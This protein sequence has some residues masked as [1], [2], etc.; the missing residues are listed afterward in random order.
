MAMDSFYDNIPADA[1][2]EIEELSRLMYE[3]RVARDQLL[4]QLGADNVEHAL[5]RL[6][7][8]ELAEH[9]HYE[10][11]LSSRILTDLILDVRAQLSER[12]A[13]SNR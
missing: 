2:L 6:E 12:V 10:H 5:Q 7:N 13:Q 3:I 1:A 11:Y 9:P 4:S 8:G